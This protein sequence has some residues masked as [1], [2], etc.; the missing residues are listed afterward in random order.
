MAFLGPEYG[1]R[2]LKN[3]VNLWAEDSVDR[4]VGAAR[5]PAVTRTIHLDVGAKVAA[6]DNAAHSSV[7]RQLGALEQRS[8]KARSKLRAC[9]GPRRGLGREP[10]LPRS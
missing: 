3:G 1:E 6:F 2:D 10:R 4:S 5:L 9:C 8:P 7:D